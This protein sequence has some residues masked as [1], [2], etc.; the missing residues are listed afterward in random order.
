MTKEWCS[1]TWLSQPTVEMLIASKNHVVCLC[2]FLF[3][4]HSLRIKHNSQHIWLQIRHKVLDWYKLQLSSSK[5]I[6]FFL[7]VILDL[8][9]GS[10][11]VVSSEYKC[12]MNSCLLCHRPDE[13]NEII[14]ATND[15][16]TSLRLT[17]MTT[18]VM[19][20]QKG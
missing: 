7:W 15:Y 2:L 17:C 20:T 3:S 13:M 19:M 4:R 10:S 14:R 5:K 12:W 8:W 16:C 1:L 11:L 9:R 18:F 6:L